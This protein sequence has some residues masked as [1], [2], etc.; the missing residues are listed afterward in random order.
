[1]S[2]DDDRHLRLAII[3]L[4]HYLPYDI[5]NKYLARLK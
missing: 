4:R 2:V 1:M 5:E 3:E